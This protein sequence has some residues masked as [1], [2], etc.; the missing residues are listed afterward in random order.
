MT[1]TSFGQVIPVTGPNIGFAGTVSRQGER[2]IAARVFTP[3]TLT[4]NLNFGD[5]AV[6]IP[7]QKGGAYDSVADFIAH[8]A[9]NIGLLAAYWAGAAVREVKTQLTYPSNVTPG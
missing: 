6:V 5:P 2:V 4:N 7:D 8:A 1:L 9:A 3:Y